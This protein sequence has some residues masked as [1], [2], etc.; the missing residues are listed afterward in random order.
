MTCDLLLAVGT[1]LAVFP[2]AGVVPIAV[3]AGARV[4]IVNGEATEMDHLADVV[5]RASISEA[6]PAI[7]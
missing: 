2:I 7:V 4:I 3:R 1:S 5:V 6:L